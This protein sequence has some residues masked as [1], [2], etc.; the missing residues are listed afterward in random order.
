MAQYEYLSANFDD[1]CIIGKATTDKLAFYGSTPVDQATGPAVAVTAAAT[2]T[3]CNT[4]V[5]ELQAALIALGLMAAA[6]S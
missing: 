6:Q 1:G 3:V 5:G 2:T 4:A